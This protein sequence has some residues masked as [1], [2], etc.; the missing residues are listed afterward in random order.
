MHF[1]HVNVLAGDLFTSVH[2]PSALKAFRSLS[3]RVPM[4]MLKCITTSKPPG[5]ELLYGS[6]LIP[7]HTAVCG[8]KSLFCSCFP[9]KTRQKPH[10]ELRKNSMKNKFL[11][12][13]GAWPEAYRILCESQVSWQAGTVKCTKVRAAKKADLL[14]SSKP[15]CVC[16]G[17]LQ[18]H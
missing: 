11:Q 2:P 1:R 6:N 18:R 13:H 4:C 8:S 5:L 9:R 16:G 15:V 17:F 14:A 7:H 12:N 3:P 10:M